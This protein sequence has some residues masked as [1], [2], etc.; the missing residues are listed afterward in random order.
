MGS[1]SGKLH[2]DKAL[3]L[4]SQERDQVSTVAVASGEPRVV[5]TLMIGRGSRRYRDP[6]LT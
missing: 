2:D 5:P 3:W 6:V 1:R 4:E